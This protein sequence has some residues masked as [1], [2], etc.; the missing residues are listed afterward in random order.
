MREE[1]SRTIEANSQKLSQD[2]INI[3]KEG[4]KIKQKLKAQEGRSVINKASEKMDSE[5]Y[6]TIH[7]EPQQK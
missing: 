5:I 3:K 7:G 1:S 2:A 4:G 6:K